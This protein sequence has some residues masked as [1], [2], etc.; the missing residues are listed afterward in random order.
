MPEGAEVEVLITGLYDHTRSVPRLGSLA[1]EGATMLRV[2]GAMVRGVSTAVGAAR[3][4]S[5]PR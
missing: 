2:L 4:A 1:R 5:A 3:G